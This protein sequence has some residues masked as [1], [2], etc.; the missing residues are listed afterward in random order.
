M[1]LSLA[2]QL[3]LA[4]DPAPEVAGTQPSKRPATAPVIKKVTHDAA[5][6]S[7]A[8]RGLDE[9]YPASFRFLEHQ[10]AWHTPFNRPGMV[11]PYDL[12]GWHSRRAPHR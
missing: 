10:G 12:R 4:A 11:G 9:P 6:Y 2:L 1:W 8:L 7:E 3:A 5:W